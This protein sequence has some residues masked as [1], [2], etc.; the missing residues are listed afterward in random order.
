MRPVRLIAAAMSSGPRIEA[1]KSPIRA[2]IH[3]PAP[4]P[5][6]SRASCEGG[7]ARA[8]SPGAFASGRSHKPVISSGASVTITSTR[9]AWISDN[10]RTLAPAS[11]P[12]T[13]MSSRPPG[14]AEKKAVGRSYPISRRKKI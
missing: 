10:E 6:A 9:V 1:P 3:Q 2:A 11:R 5:I 4:P 7:T 8:D 14:I 13:I 12:K